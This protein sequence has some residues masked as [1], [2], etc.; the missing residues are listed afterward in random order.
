M[1]PEDFGREPKPNLLQ[2][3]LA[4]GLSAATARTQVMLSLLN[5]PLPP[6]HPAPWVKAA[7]LPATPGSVW[8][9]KAPKHITVSFKKPCSHPERFWVCAFL[10]EQEGTGRE[11]DL[12]TPKVLKEEFR[13]LHQET[14]TTKSLF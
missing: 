10:E 8:H 13:H 6:Q 3:E 7:G 11:W 12:K 14:L 1:L 9:T 2:T 4:L 5:L